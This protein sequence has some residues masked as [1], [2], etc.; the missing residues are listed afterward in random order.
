MTLWIVPNSQKS[1]KG[2]SVGPFLRPQALLGALAAE[3]GAGS[4]ISG[5]PML[6]TADDATEDRLTVPLRQSIFVIGTT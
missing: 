3:I 1:N 2:L 4:D 6:G 5:F